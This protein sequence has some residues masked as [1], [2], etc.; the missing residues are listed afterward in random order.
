M[1]LS[2]WMTNEKM[3]EW[4]YEFPFTSPVSINSLILN[5][6]PQVQRLW[7]HVGFCARIADESIYKVTKVL[8]MIFMSVFKNQDNQDT[9][10]YSMTL[11]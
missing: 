5:K 3:N 1:A 11:W 7:K 6:G 8:Y 2:K 10:Y 9:I 4:K